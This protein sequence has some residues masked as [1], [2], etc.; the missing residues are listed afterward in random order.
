[1]IEVCNSISVFP[2]YE[3]IY[4]L[5]VV[6]YKKRHWMWNRAQQKKAQKKWNG[7]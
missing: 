1:M 5:S 2:I 6:I 7:K 4:E 3:S